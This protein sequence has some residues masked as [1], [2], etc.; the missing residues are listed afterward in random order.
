MKKRM[1]RTYGLVA[2]GLFIG[3]SALP[4][5]AKEKRAGS[6]TDHGLDNNRANYVVVSN[7]FRE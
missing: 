3:A 7:A 5:M 2:F 1:N 6:A 4:A